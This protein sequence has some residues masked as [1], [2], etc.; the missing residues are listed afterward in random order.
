MAVRRSDFRDAD[1]EVAM[2]DGRALAWRISARVRRWREA[3][4]RSAAMHRSKNEEPPEG[5]SSHG[6]R[7]RE[8]P[9]H[10]LF[11]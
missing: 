11:L 4:S 9:R 2:G 7:W 8:A 1:N 3:A 10:G 5:V 6:W